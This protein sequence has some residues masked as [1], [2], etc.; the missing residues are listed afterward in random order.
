MAAIDDF[1]F[2]A[3]LSIIGLAA[4]SIGCVLF[5]GSLREL[6]LVCFRIFAIVSSRS[7]SEI[8]IETQEAH[9]EKMLLRTLK[10][11]SKESMRMCS[12]RGKRLEVAFR[13]DVLRIISRR[14]GIQENTDLLVNLKSH[15]TRSRAR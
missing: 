7:A 9:L 10:A 13:P 6:F 8:R 5:P 3:E 15:T 14:L 12:M 1:F 11:T 2:S 4:F